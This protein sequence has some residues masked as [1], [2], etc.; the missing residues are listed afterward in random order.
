MAN[1]QSYWLSYCLLARLVEHDPMLHDWL[2]TDNQLLAK[3][4]VEADDHPRMDFNDYDIGHTS[5]WHAFDFKENQIPTAAKNWKCFLLAGYIIV[6]I[7][8]LS[9]HEIPVFNCMAIF[10]YCLP[11]CISWTLLNSVFGTSSFFAMKPPELCLFFTWCQ[12]LHI[13]S[14]GLSS[15]GESKS[16]PPVSRSKAVKEINGGSTFALCV[17]KVTY[18]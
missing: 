7:T 10:H 12:M 15:S 9:G 13:F 6:H 4:R 18:Q 1:L 14:V 2:I 16:K 11:S 3:T 5:H 8:Y 17:I